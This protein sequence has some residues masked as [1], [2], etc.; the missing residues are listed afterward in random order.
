[1]LDVTDLEKE[2]SFRLILCLLAG[3]EPHAK[4]QTAHHM[5]MFGCDDV[6]QLHGHW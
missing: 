4:M 3:Y 1:M 6:K 5:L 2:L